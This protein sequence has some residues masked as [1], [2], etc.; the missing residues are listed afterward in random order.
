MEVNPAKALPPAGLGFWVSDS[1]FRVLVFGFWVSGSGFRVLDFGFWVSGFGFRVPV[2]E[3]WV[4]RVVGREAPV[5][6]A[7]GEDRVE[8][9]H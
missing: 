5:E 4:S 7:E 9:D 6:G 2:L 8:A 1:G 3:R